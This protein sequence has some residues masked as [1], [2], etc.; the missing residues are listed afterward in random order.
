LARLDAA[1]RRLP[2]L[3]L[4]L[5]TP[6]KAMQRSIAPSWTALW[7]VRRAPVISSTISESSSS[8]ASK[9]NCTRW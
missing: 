8:G 6:P 3:L 9:L 1:Q 4:A 5:P 2:T 7:A